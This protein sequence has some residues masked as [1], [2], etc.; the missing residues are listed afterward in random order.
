MA[1]DFDIYLL[2]D[3]IAL[4]GVPQ[5]P[6]DLALV[7]Y[8]LLHRQLQAGQLK[9]LVLLTFHGAEVRPW[10]LSG[11]PPIPI[12]DVVRSLSAQVGCDALTFVYEAPV[13]QGVVAD[14]AFMFAADG[15]NG[16]FN[17]MILVRGEL[18]TPT[19]MMQAGQYGTVRTTSRWLGVPT[20]HKIGLYRKDGGPF[21]GPTQGEA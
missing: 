7:A 19:A 8:E 13:P 21:G 20:P 4:S 11:T 9:T 5:S 6:Q 3:P 15:P 12:D 16:S 2:R 10:I 1:D 14:R 17:V 18:G